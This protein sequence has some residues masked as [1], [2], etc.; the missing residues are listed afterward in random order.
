MATTKF[1]GNT[2]NMIGEM[3][4]EGSKAPNF[5]LTKSDLSEASLDNYKGKRIVLN[6]FP[7][8]DTPVC[9][10][11][12]RKFNKEVS[13]LKNTVVLCISRDLPFA[14]HR[15]CVAEGIKNV[16]TLSDYKTADFADNYGVLMSDGPLA[17][18]L[19]RSVFLIDENEIIVYKELV[20]DI[21]EEPNYEAVFKLLR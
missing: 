21:T 1:K 14:Q 8:L 9:A 5:K 17:K 6:I 7:S 2:V 12:V 19:A 10:M 4:K 15:F 3:P 20:E 11:S 16:E 18:L 13:D